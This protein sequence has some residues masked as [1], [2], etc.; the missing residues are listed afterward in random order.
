M[1][2]AALVELPRQTVTEETAAEGRPI[3][4]AVREATAAHRTAEVVAAA[5]ATL[6]SSG[7]AHF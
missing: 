7:G 6:R 4:A 1:E 3:R 2:G 5:V